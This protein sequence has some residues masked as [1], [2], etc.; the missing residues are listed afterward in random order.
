MN[1]R[2]M[3]NWAFTEKCY[4]NDRC[5]RREQ[6]FYTKKVITFFVLTTNLNCKNDGI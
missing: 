6:I 3:Y 5:E 2:G 1:A 4:R